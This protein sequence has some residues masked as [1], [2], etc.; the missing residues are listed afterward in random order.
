LLQHQASLGQAITSGADAIR[1]SDNHSLPLIWHE[2]QVIVVRFGRPEHVSRGVD[3]LYEILIHRLTCLIQERTSLGI[4]PT[5]GLDRIQK[6]P[7][8][9]HGLLGGY[10]Q[11]S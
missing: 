3:Q 9:L 8:R 6:S 2:D 4:M 1:C 10:C 7:A 5:D 11:L